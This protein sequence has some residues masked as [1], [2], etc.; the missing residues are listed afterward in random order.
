MYRIHVLKVPTT[1]E[2]LF[3]YT[4]YNDMNHDPYFKVRV[5]KGMLILECIDLFKLKPNVQAKKRNRIDV[6][7]PGYSAIEL[8]SK[9][10]EIFGPGDIAELNKIDPELYRVGS[11][12]LPII[13]ESRNVNYFEAY[14][15]I[16]GYIAGGNNGRVFVDLEEPNE[17]HIEMLGPEVH[18][19]IPIQS[20]SGKMD[21][22]LIFEEN[23]PD[24][25]IRVEGETNPVKKSKGAV[26]IVLNDIE[27]RNL[28]TT[29]IYYGQKI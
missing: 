24:V 28:A 1:N 13:K 14:I 2:K 6:Y 4:H 18:L 8:G 22:N 25:E 27:A 10:I 16:G 5:Q 3:P 29:L 7:I 11:Q 9:I 12:T 23:V 19:G 17:G 21:M 20:V 26:L 15:K